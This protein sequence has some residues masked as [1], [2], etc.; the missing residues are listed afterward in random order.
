[1]R[2]YWMLGLFGGMALT[3]PGY[4][5]D[6]KTG[7]DDV[8][9]TLGGEVRARYDHRKNLTYTQG[10]VHASDD[11]SSLRT[12]LN[13][14]VKIGDDITAHVQLQDSH[15]NGAATTNNATGAS[16]S[17]ADTQFVMREGYLAISDLFDL[18]LDL[19]VGRKS[20][21]YGHGRLISDSD[22]SNSPR[23]FDVAALKYR[24]DESTWLDILM[25]DAQNGGVNSTFN[26]PRRADDDN[27][28]YLLY[29]HTEFGSTKVD[30]YNIW[31]RDGL[32]DRGGEKFAALGGPLV[33]GKLNRHTTGFLVEHSFG[34]FNASFEYMNQWG[35]AGTDNIDAEAYALE[36]GYALGDE[37][38]TEFN[39][40][41]ASA[42]GNN[43]PAD[44]KQTR[45]RSPFADSHAYHGYA[46]LVGF[47]NMESHKFQVASNV[48]GKTRAK[49]AWHF[50]DR[51]EKKDSWY[52]GNGAVQRTGAGSGGGVIFAQGS[53]S[54]DIGQEIDL[55]ID[56]KYNDHLNFEL[57]WAHFMEGTLARE[58]DPTLGNVDYTWLQMTLKF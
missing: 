33:V 41:Y 29:G 26:E 19:I 27:D 16:G 11:T 1:M 30:V 5:G 32:A 39:Y 8:E 28:I 12:R 54:S 36:V 20:L 7:S 44:G 55:T 38:E 46:D 24:K 4:G 21:N 34:D 40:E 9:I 23:H 15:T 47:T 37:A 57:G 58:T 42:S 49:A 53:S 52:A 13:V 6:V 10:A 22:W 31:E 48:T 2:K 14:G 17:T 43:D 56:H 25:I 45:F 18:P 51:K 35:E 50:F 3:F